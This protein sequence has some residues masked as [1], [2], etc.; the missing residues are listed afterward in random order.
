MTMWLYLA[1]SRFMCPVL[2][3]K[4]TLPLYLT[5]HYVMKTYVGVYV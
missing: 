3:I 5:R 2:A 1:A 4:V